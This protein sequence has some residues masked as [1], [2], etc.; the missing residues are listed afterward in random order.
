MMLKNL[1]LKMA[2]EM[3]TSKAKRQQIHKL[4]EAPR[5]RGK[6]QI[7]SPK[8]KAAFFSLFGT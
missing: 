5:R 1:W 2:E 8:R 7:A 4:P 6:A 3:E